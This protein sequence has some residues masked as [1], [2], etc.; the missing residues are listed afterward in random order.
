[1]LDYAK[2]YHGDT[3]LS[4]LYQ[5]DDLIWEKGAPAPSYDETK[6]AVVLLD[7]HDEPTDEIEYFETIADTSTYLKNNTSSRYLVNIGKQTGVDTIVDDAFSEC[8][9]LVLVSLPIGV[10]SIGA[11]AFYH[12]S[13]TSIDI[14]FGVTTIGEAAF[15]Y[16]PEL[17]TV[18]IP[19]SVLSISNYA[20]TDCTSLTSVDIPDSVTNLGWYSFGECSSLSNVSLSS[21]LTVI[22]NNMFIRCTSLTSIEIPNG[23]TTIEYL[24]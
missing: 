10:T 17:V 15:R 11:S 13:L 23:V 4:R 2:M 1:M 3:A 6:I 9:S 12:T 16:C 19:D 20:F 24:P 14:P 18:N 8:F 22:E 21:G 7:E 5:G